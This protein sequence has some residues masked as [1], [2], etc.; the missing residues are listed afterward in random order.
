MENKGKIL[1]QKYEIGKLLGQGNFAKVYHASNLETGQIVAV[2][3]TD[4][5]KNLKVGMVDQIKREIVL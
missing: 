4:K 3:V 5:E 2:K 1:L